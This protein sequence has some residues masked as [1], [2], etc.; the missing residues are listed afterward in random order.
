VNHSRRS[1]TRRSALGIIASVV[2][3]SEQKP[4]AD[5]DLPHTMTTMMAEQTG[6]APPKRF[7][8]V[9]QRMIQGREM[10]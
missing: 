8:F 7:A 10:Q 9:R 6:K 3:A 2:T 5:V 4:D 1:R